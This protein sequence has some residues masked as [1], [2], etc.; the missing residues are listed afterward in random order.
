MF[1]LVGESVSEDGFVL[2]FLSVAMILQITLLILN[3]PDLM[4]AIIS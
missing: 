3:A 2:V 1:A 4:L